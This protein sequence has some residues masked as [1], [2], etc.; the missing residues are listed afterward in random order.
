M[1]TAKR[2]DG[3]VG[4]SVTRAGIVTGGASGIGRAISRRLA[5][6]G[7]AVAIF[8]RDG[9][10]AA[11]CAAEITRAGGRA[12]AHQLDVTQR[13]EL[14]AGTDAA[15][16]AHG[17][18]WFLVNA[19]GWDRPTPFL[20]SDPA[21]WARIVDINLY[22]PLNTHHIVC[23]H[24]REQGGGRVV[25]IAS[26]AGRTGAGN[27]AV[28]SA[29][30]GGMIALTRSLAREFA[31]WNILLNTISPG[32]TDTPLLASFGDTEGLARQIPLRR[33]GR[34][35]DFAGITAFLIGDDAGY[36]TG[37]TLSVSGGLTMV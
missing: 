2:E 1:T 25:N 4:S 26:D 13:A 11:E 8:D 24:M 27:V 23:R 9:I 14:Q 18:L 12:T 34:P 32:P 20:D 19:A 5:A 7:H 10:A 15:I 17:P 30:K 16:A 33:L 22:G 6:D 31:R 29:C 21:L 35:E 28:Y 37:Q 36:I 3:I